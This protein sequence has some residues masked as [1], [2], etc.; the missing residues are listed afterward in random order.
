ME[1]KAN[2]GN[3]IF[4]HF[5]R[6]FRVTRAHT[7]MLRTM[8]VRCRNG[9]CQKTIVCTA[10]GPQN[11]AKHPKGFAWALSGHTMRLLLGK[12]SRSLSRWYYILSFC[13]YQFYLEVSQQQVDFRQ[14]LWG[15][16]EKDCCQRRNVL[17]LSK[18][19]R[20]LG[21]RLSWS[22]FSRSGNVSW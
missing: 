10:V 17:R 20:R 14:L 3:W 18:T 9:V 7:C 2:N 4:Q 19:G 13:A 8:T 1:S 16:R 5:G 22:H 21:Q 6:G 15:E 11:A 12:V